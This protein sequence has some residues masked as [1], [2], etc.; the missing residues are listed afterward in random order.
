[1]TARLAGAIILMPR[2]GAADQALL[3][4]CLYSP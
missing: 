4:A 2:P 3:A 1:M